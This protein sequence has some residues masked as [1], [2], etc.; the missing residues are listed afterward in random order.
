VIQGT[1]RWPDKRYDRGVEWKEGV[2]PERSERFSSRRTL[3]RSVQCKKIPHAGG[4]PLAASRR[5]DGEP[6]QVAGNLAQALSLYFPFVMSLHIS[7]AALR[8]W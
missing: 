6:V 5:T 3:C 4:V 1:Q 2:L 8:A 7:G